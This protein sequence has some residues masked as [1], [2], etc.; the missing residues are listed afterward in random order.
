MSKAGCLSITFLFIIIPLLI[1]SAI[2]EAEEPGKSGLP[3]ASPSPETGEI[4]F[5]KNPKALGTPPPPL[6]RPDA[7]HV[8]IPV[9]LSSGERSASIKDICRSAGIALPPGKPPA[10]VKLTPARLTSGKSWMAVFNGAAV[11]YVLYPRAAG[12]PS[13]GIEGCERAC[14]KDPSCVTFK[15]AMPL[16]ELYCKSPPGAVIKP[17]AAESFI[18]LYFGE[19]VPGKTYMLDLSVG[20]YPPHMDNAWQISG[21]YEGRVRPRKGHIIIGFTA[22]NRETTLKLAFAGNAQFTKGYFFSA[23]L[24]RLD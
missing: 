6:T 15:F 4:V 5:S 8:M 17:G 11:P 18:Y 7:E 12:S 16:C 1:G 9:P 21:A 2:T 13:G 3:A 20:D 19:T 10:Q 24:T 22:D 14:R 23:E